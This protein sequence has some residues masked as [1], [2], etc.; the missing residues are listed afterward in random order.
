MGRKSKWITHVEPKLELIESWCRDGDIET[1]ICKKL[2]ISV[3][4][5]NEYKKKYPKLVETL[6]NGKEVI[7]VE[8]ENALLRRA[9]GYE[10]KETTITTDNKGLKVEKEI[11]KQVIPS[12][13]AQIFWLKNRKTK[14]WSDRRVIETGEDLSVNINIKGTKD[15]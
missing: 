5:L 8:V 1:T 3:S 12:T 11:I 10:T 7:D 9:L 6:K 14:E 2:G 15:E 4:V 13:T